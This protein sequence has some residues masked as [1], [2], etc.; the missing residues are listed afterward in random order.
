MV[1]STSNALDNNN[2]SNKILKRQGLIDFSI[3]NELEYYNTSR[4]TNLWY[5]GIL[6][7]FYV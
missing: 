3:D 2:Y 5:S 6:I 1:G 7:P 4:I